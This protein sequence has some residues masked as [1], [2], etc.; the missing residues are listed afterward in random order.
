MSFLHRRYGLTGTALTAEAGREVYA[1]QE[2]LWFQTV[3]AQNG[4][5]VPI[6]W[7]KPMRQLV[8][9][10]FVLNNIPPDADW[11]EA[12]RFPA[13]RDSLLQH[14]VQRWRHT[15]I[16]TVE[17]KD[18]SSLPQALPEISSVLEGKRVSSTVRRGAELF[19]VPG[20][21]NHENRGPEQVGSSFSSMGC[22]Q[23]AFATVAHFFWE[24][25]VNSLRV[26]RD[27]LWSVLL[28]I[29]VGKVGNDL[30]EETWMKYDIPEARGG[31]NGR[32]PETEPA[33]TLPSASMSTVVDISEYHRDHYW[34]TEKAEKQSVRELQPGGSGEQRRLSLLYELWG[35]EE[36]LRGYGF[37]EREL[38]AP[39]SVL[40]GLAEYK[41]VSVPEM[42]RTL[43]SGGFFEK[44]PDNPRSRSFADPE[45]LLTVMR[46]G[47]KWCFW[48]WM[49][50]SLGQNWHRVVS[51]ADRFALDVAKML[52]ASSH[53]SF[54]VLHRSCSRFRSAEEARAWGKKRETSQDKKGDTYGTN[55]LDPLHASCELRAVQNI[56]S[57]LLAKCGLPEGGVDVAN[58]VEYIASAVLSLEQ[59]L[60][61][62]K[63]QD[64]MMR[65]EVVFF[66]REKGRVDAATAAGML[67]NVRDTFV[68]SRSL[69]QSFLVQGGRM[70]LASPGGNDFVPTKLE[71]CGFLCD[72]EN[73]KC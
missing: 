47:S 19:R 11:D 68:L 58:L 54:F 62:S 72:M 17:G 35:I 5:R 61:T 25:R 2:R 29:P 31:G 71:C 16:R 57:P 60:L 50:G 55:P 28:Q 41:G 4:L 43:V 40:K 70:I 48:S 27:V 30:G 45:E 8:L 12:E 39:E 69:G 42:K 7:V 46:L 44:P 51:H 1:A 36:A 53:K 67:E 20:R 23:G 3:L 65:Q 32:K 37:V 18:T 21:A 24:S 9:D 10:E 73:G 33:S 34:G 63:F 26:R 6:S 14:I 64:W 15:P 52:D 56:A 22:W 59:D 13:A 66:E 49:F 38:R